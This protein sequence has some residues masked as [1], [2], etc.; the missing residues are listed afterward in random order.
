[1]VDTWT[2]ANPAGALKRFCLMSSIG[3]TRRTSFPYIILNGGGVL[4][5]KQKGEDAVTS[6]AQEFG[7]EYTIV[8]PGQLTGVH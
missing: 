2:S 7:F 3:V 8:R 5:A 1:M 6:A 4:D